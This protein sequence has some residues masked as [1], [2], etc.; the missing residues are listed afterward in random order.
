MK[1]VIF[2]T[3][4][5]FIRDDAW[6][7]EQAIRSWIQ[8]QGIEKKIIVVGNDKGTKEICEK[9]DLIHHP[10]VKTF[11]GVPYVYD[12]LMIG[13]SYAEEED[14]LIWTN[15]DMI[16]FQDMFDNILEFDKI[17]QR[18]KLDK[19]IMVGR[20][21]DWMNPKILENFN[22]EEILKNIKMNRGRNVMISKRKSPKIELTLHAES[23]V[24][25]IIHSK[26]TYENNF[27]PNLV[28]SGTGHDLLL[29]RKCIDQGIYNCNITGTNF[30]I[31]QNHDNIR[32]REKLVEKLVKNNTKYFHWTDL[33]N[34]L[35]C[36]KSTKFDDH[37][38]I[39]F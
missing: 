29:L 28:I 15:C 22:K 30:C 27:N 17:R 12:M 38:K 18:D 9:Y 39:I 14:Y 16:Y 11:N 20:R 34:I 25:Y 32:Y 8:L 19:F 31:H 24:D 37:N 5:P 35:N 6:R 26:S 36:K 3:C 23:G 2:T 33:R 7:Q 21:H 4:K 1:V 13:A 10:E